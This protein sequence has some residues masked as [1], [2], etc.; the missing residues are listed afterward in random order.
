MGEILDFPSFDGCLAIFSGGLM[1]VGEIAKGGPAINGLSGIW[2]KDVQIFP[3]SAQVDENS[4]L[5]MGS[6]YLPFS[7]IS[8][9]SA[10]PEVG[11]PEPD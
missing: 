11:F 7:G 1:F 6:V 9:I 8:A 4:V 2:L 5:K 3:V 10:A